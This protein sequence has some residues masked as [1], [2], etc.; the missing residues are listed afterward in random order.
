MQSGCRKP[1][2]G[3]S[4]VRPPVGSLVEALSELPVNLVVPETSLALRSSVPSK[5][6]WTGSERGK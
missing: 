1:C 3:P 6:A 2:S 4:A 5:L